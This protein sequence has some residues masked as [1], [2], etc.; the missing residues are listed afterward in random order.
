MRKA[1]IAS[2]IILLLLISLSSPIM[3]SASDSTISTD[4]TWSGQQTLSGNLTIAQ[5]ATLTILPGTTIDCGDNYWIE[6]DG[7]LIANDANFFSSTPPVTQGSHGAGLWK[8][9]IINSGGSAF[10]NDTLI[11]NA[12]TGILVNGELNA[13]S[14]QIFDSYIGINN[15]AT[16]TIDGYHSEQIDYD[17]IQNSG[18]LELSNAEI[19]YSATGI[20]TSGTST[21]TNSNFSSVGVALKNLAGQ[22]TAE[23]IKFDF[24]TVGISSQISAKVS[25]SN[26]FG[27]DIALL[28]DAANSDDLTVEGVSASGNRILVSNGATS[29]TISNVSFDGSID[30]N[31]PSI[32]Q[33]CTG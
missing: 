6:V 26:V 11:E 28:I 10:I 21:V 5:G 12:K 17:S 19:E 27:Q 30:S 20:H 22:T 2:A 3:V 4:I 14:I 33:R 32:D 8:G 29:L 18:T 1:S 25:V 24:V 13:N 7:T 16:S 31:S 15:M 23:N 9:L